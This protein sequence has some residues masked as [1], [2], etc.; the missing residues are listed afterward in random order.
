MTDYLTILE[1]AA[2]QQDLID[3]YG[4]SHGIRDRGALDSAC[5]RPQSGYYNNIIEEAAALMESLAMN[6]P[7]IDGNK[8]IAFA[9]TY[10]FLKINGY[11]ITADALDIYNFI[12][13]SLEKGQF[14]IDRIISYVEVNICKI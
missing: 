2:I 9:A 7:F 4:G 13:K 12:I 14:T 1:I 5:N 8:R 6:H 3:R 11:E 10:T